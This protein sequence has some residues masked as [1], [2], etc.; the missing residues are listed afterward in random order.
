MWPPKCD[1]RRGRGEVNT[2]FVERLRLGRNRM[3]NALNRPIVSN[4]RHQSTDLITF[5]LPALLQSRSG[6]AQGFSDTT[7]EIHC[8]LT[9]PE[10]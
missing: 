7:I 9:R 2:V 6:I 5:A 3:A 1:P 8:L 4:L 10:W